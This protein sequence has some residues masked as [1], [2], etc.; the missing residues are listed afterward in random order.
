M[1]N[2]AVQDQTSAALR[3]RSAETSRPRVG[4]AGL[5]WIG[6]SRLEAV[7]QTGLVEISAVSDPDPKS[8]AL[9]DWQ[10]CKLY[11]GIES[12]LQQHLDAV[13][14]ATP[15]GLHKAHTLAALN[16]GMA[17]FCQKPLGL[18]TADVKLMTETAKRQ[19]RLLGVD[20][21]YRH[22]SGARDIRRRI[23]DGEIGRVYAVDLVFHNA[24]G[25]DKDW[26]YDFA[27][28]GGGCVA[29]L[30]IHLVDLAL[31]T[32]N[33]PEIKT[34]SS[35]IF[36]QGRRLEPPVDQVEDFASARLDTADGTVINLTC[37][38]NL[39]AGCDAV[40]QA[41]FYGRKGSLRLENVNGSFYEFRAIQCFGTNRHLLEHPADQWYG[42]AAAVWAEKLARSGAY[43]SEIEQM[44]T[45]TD[46]LDRIYERPI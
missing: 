4:F 39:S 17:V 6:K 40:I 43:D 46:V 41:G 2:V 14:I 8:L 35:R 42:R 5:G 3:E 13:V 31:W 16:R 20:L 25:P 33:W 7:A 28:S 22:V 10:K 38:W 24:Y 15:T 37:S 45:V 21:S 12:M 30:G 44:I 36:R 18:C 11:D 26:Y 23:T 9:C 19:N 32:L 34:V 1:N 29:D 27:S